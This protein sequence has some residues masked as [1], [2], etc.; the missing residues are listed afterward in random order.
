MNL[1]RITDKFGTT[2]KPNT[3]LKSTKKEQSFGLYE[4]DEMAEA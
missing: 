3:L 4:I 2:F 1:K